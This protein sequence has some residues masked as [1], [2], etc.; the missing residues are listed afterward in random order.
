MKFGHVLMHL[1]GFHFAGSLRTEDMNF[2]IKIGTAAGK[3]VSVS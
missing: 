3:F 1:V 2:E